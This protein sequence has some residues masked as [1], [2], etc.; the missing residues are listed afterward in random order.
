MQGMNVP[1]WPVNPTWMRRL[2]R[3]L[4]PSTFS[5]MITRL[6]PKLAADAAFFIRIATQ[7]LHRNPL[8]LV[9]P[10]LHATGGKFPGLELFADVESALAHADRLLGGGPQR[11]VVFPTGGTTY[12]IPPDDTPKAGA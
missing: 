5:S 7:T 10:I 1:K 9:S 11:V 2:I 4:G 12:P 8:L 6:A 3:W